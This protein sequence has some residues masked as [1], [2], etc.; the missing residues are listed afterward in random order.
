[1]SRFAIR[2]PYFVEFAKHLIENGMAVRDAV[3]TWCHV[4]LRPIVMTTLGTGSE[5]YAPLARAVAGGLSVSGLCAVLVA[6]AAFP[7]TYRNH[8]IRQEAS[9]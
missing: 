5:S 3:I 4:R 9:N 8:P 1:M 6:P 7:L 2:N